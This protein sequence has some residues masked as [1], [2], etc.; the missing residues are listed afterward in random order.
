MSDLLKCMFI[1][2]FSAGC[3]PAVV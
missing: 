3:H 1:I 2:H